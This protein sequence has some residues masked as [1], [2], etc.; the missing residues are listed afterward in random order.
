METWPTTPGEHLLKGSHLK[1]G[2]WP[3][4]GLT[5]DF[6]N[7]VVTGSVRLSP[8]ETLTVKQRGDAEWV[9]WCW[10]RE[11]SGE[12]S[13]E[14]SWGSKNHE[15]AGAV[16]W[17]GKGGGSDHWEREGKTKTQQ[18]L[19]NWVANLAP[20]EDFRWALRWYLI[21]RAMSEMSQVTFPWGQ[22]CSYRVGS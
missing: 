4:I 17:T 12:N 6:A 21:T 22:Q 8:F 19:R 5:W 13:K 16:R 9:N 18:D 7:T 11:R 14:E 3:M 15:E 10:I 20:E 1:A 2:Q